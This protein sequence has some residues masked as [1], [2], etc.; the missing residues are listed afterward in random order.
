MN[1]YPAFILIFVF[2][3]CSS[4]KDLKVV[5]QLDIKKY[6]GTWFEIAR[7]PNSFEKKLERVSATYSLR[8]DGRIDVFNK[9][10]LIDQPQKEKNIKGVAWLPDESSP[11][12]LKVRFFWPFAGDYWVL[13]LD[14][15]YNY[16]LVGDPSRKYLWILGR[17]KTLSE[18]IIKELAEIARQ[19]GF[20]VTKLARVKQDS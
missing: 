9:G 1:Y 13:A 14:K 11:A 12:K 10:Y 6:Q 18:S 8:K 20:D 2:M 17:E 7:F 5:D 16:A 3:S 4:P 15:D 19:K